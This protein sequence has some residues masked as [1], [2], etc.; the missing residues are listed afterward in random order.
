MNWVA[1]KS[2]LGGAAAPVAPKTRGSASMAAPPASVGKS[3]HKPENFRLSNGLKDFLWLLSD[4]ENGRLLDL[5]QVSQAT[6]NFFIERGFRVTT[7]DMLRSWKEFQRA[8]EEKQRKAPPSDFNE[9]L[10]PEE[11]AQH[12]LQDSLQYADDEF[13]A[14]LIWDIFDRLDAE[15]LSRIAN[16]LYEIVRPGGAVLALFHSKAPER[17]YRYRIVDNQTIEIVPIGPAG[18]HLRVF[19]NRE[20]LNLFSRFRSAKTFVG[21]DQLREGLFIK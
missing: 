9:P 11:I 13:N 2:R 6:L 3:S 5:G 16:R 14:V 1:G 18:A 4:V 20:I 15:L 10:S 19:Q 21:R 7:D 8:E 12:F 17:T